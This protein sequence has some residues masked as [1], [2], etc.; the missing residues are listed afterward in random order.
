MHCQSCPKSC[1]PLRITRGNFE[2][3]CGLNHSSTNWVRSS[4]ARP[5]G[6]CPLI[7]PHDSPVQPGLRSLCK[8]L[9]YSNFSFWCVWAVPCIVLR[10]LRDS[11]NHCTHSSSSSNICFSTVSR[12]CL[13]PTPQLCSM[14]NFL[15]YANASI[16]ILL[17]PMGIDSHAMSLEI[18]ETSEVSEGVVRWLSEDG[19]QE[20]T[21]IQNLSSVHWGFAMYFQVGY[22]IFSS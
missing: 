16:F 2:N 12:L 11:T 9:S 17:S 21:G 22:Y 10:E 3:C 6:H 15:K 19:F 14:Q 20:Q 1:Q 13:P 8:L 4:W 7:R 18:L 5:S